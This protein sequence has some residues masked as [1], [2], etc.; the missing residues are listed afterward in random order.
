MKINFIVCCDSKAGIARDGQIPWNFT[1]DM[2]HFRETT[3]GGIVIMG[4]KTWQT[5][6]RELPGR[7]S[8]VMT[9]GN[10][11]DESKPPE[12]T[13]GDLVKYDGFV[14]C[15][16]Q[17]SYNAIEICKLIQQYNNASNIWIIGGQEIYESFIKEHKES[18]GK[19][20]LTQID[21]DFKCDRYFPND[22]ISIN[23]QIENTISCFDKKTGTIYEL[24]FSKCDIIVKA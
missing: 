19:L 23:I 6:K 1:E 9:R 11:D 7:H 14:R 17:N 22:L 10:S 24:T 5:L 8:I 3:M 4:K 12:T 18:L 16:A 15:T 20:Y 2:K 13:I 21:G